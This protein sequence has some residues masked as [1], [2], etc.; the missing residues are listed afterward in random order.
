MKF[1][2]TYI[3]ILI[4]FIS[5][6][7]TPHNIGDTYQGGIIFSLDGNGG[8]LV[9]APSDQSIDENGNN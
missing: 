5:F 3:F 4:S 9:T 1:I 7:Q 2:F 6:S 8:G